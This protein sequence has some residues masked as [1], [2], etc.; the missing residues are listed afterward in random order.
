MVDFALKGVSVS[1]RND[2]D[3]DVTTPWSY[4]RK[5]CIRSKAYEMMSC[6]QGIVDYAQALLEKEG[7]ESLRAKE[8]LTAATMTAE[9]ILREE[10]NLA[11]G[12]ASCEQWFH[13]ARKQPFA[14]RSLQETC[15]T[16]TWMRLCETML[17]V[18]GH[19]AQTVDFS[20]PTAAYAFRNARIENRKLWF[21]QGNNG[22]QEGGGLVF[23]DGSEVVYQCLG[24]N[25]GSG[26]R[27][28]TGATLMMTNSSVNF[29]SSRKRELGYGYVLVNDAGSSLVATNAN[30]RFGL[31][32]R[33][34]GLYVLDGAR[35]EVYDLIV[36]WGTASYSGAPGDVSENYSCFAQVSNSTLKAFNLHLG[37]DQEPIDGPKLTIAGESAQVAVE[38]VSIY[39]NT[40]AELA[41]VLPAGGFC[42][43]DGNVRAPFRA[44]QVELVP[45]G[46]LSAREKSRLRVPKK[47]GFLFCIR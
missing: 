1:D 2:P 40:G 26:L 27:V 43:A 32:G 31:S 16:V 24:F 23:S 5:S 22:G 29:T 13:G 38:T 28:E 47:E 39:E 19:K 15:T 8:L 12:C 17:A 14:Y 44:R 37:Y 42:D 7:K 11:G 25:N 41:F 36:G 35:M 33:S 4:V 30:F 18:T 20:L 34:T 3:Y 6:Y 45:R 21:T 9:D 46:S 10:I